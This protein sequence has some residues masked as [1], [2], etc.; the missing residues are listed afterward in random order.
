MRPDVE[1]D[2]S[3]DATKRERES[4]GIE[5]LEGIGWNLGFEFGRAAAKERERERVL[6]CLGEEEEKEKRV[7]PRV[8]Q[9][10]PRPRTPLLFFFFIIPLFYFVSSSLRFYFLFYYKDLDPR[11][12]AFGNYHEVSFLNKRTNKKQM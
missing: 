2:R 11:P 1:F 6:V 3:L 4:E 7:L 5:T 8:I 9:I 12:S 10:D